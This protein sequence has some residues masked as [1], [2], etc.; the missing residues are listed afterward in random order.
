M[1]IKK[2]IYTNYEFE[3]LCD[4]LWSGADE[5]LKK[6]IEEGKCEEFNALIEELYPE[7]IDLTSLNDLLR[8]D[9]EWIFETLGIEEEE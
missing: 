2:E 7:G 9:E 5:T 4:D 8:F 6:I 3:A 1:T